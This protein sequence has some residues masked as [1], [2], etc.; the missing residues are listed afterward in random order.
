MPDVFAGKHTGDPDPTVNRGPGV[1]DGPEPVFIGGP[2]VD[3][4]LLGYV[5]KR[6][7]LGDV[8]VLDEIK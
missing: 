1:E 8:T 4:E 3:P 7:V 6:P 5:K 2:A